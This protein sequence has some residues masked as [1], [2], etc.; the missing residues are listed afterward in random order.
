VKQAIADQLTLRS[1]DI[2]F[3]VASNP[4]F[5]KEGSA[6]EDFLKPDRIV[7]GVEDEAVKETMKALYSPFNR[8]RDR[9]SVMDVI[10]AELTKYAANSM[11]ATKIS[12]MNEMANI[13]ERVGADIENVRRGIG[14]DPRIGHHF[15]Y[16]GCGYGGSCFPKD[17][18]ALASTA[19][20]LGY[21]TPLLDAV[22]LVNER[23]KLVPI[24]KIKRRF[25]DDLSGRH[26]AIWGLAFKPNTDD[27]REAPSILVIRELIAAGATIAAFDPVARR[28]AESEFRDLEGLSFSDDPYDA[29]RGAHALLL[30]TEWSVF[31]SPDL[32]RMA[33]LLEEKVIIDGR[34]VFDPDDM[35]RDGFEYFGIGRGE[36][37]FD[38]LEQ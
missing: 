24:R 21:D 4:E 34:N 19:K 28:T 23:Q 25:G 38:S 9:L 22:E 11:L 36:P 15:I 35:R 14:S 30:L 17:I 5:L 10:S 27:M 31:R 7:I 26:F 2:Q 16:P 29:L 8:N 32:A 13:A 3:Y 1:L 18:S 33:D 37:Q 20:L 12:F 6:I